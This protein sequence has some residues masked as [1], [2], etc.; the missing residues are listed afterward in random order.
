MHHNGEP[1]R[2]SFSL[3]GEVFVHDNIKKVANKPT[4][5]DMLPKFKNF[6]KKS[7]EILIKKG[8]LSQNTHSLLKP[9]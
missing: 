4:C 3:I 8:N 9:Y 6:W 5:G 2:T 7:G 1:P